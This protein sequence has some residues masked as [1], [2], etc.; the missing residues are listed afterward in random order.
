MTCTKISS[1]S[2]GHI[3]LNSPDLA[4]GKDYKL[5]P[6]GGRPWDWNE[7]GTRHSPG[8]Q[9]GDVE[10]LLQA[11]AKEVVLS[12]GM[13]LKLRVPDET[14]RW[15][16]ERG[17]KVHVAETKEAVEIYNH[18]VDEGVSVGGCFHSDLLKVRSVS[19]RSA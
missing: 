1:I 2:W 11:G 5:F 19:G 12:R 4:D 10:E 17:V 9:Q 14:V 16:E 8:I 15:L 3:A 6:A 7:T 13:D 18:L